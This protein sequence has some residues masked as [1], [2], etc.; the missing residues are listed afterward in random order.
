MSQ[1]EDDGQRLV[2]LRMRDQE[3][4]QEAFPAAGRPEHERVAHVVH[5]QIE[6]YGV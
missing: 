1:I 2:L 3:V 4:E 6:K 5:V